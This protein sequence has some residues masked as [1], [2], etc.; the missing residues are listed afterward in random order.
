MKT[1]KVKTITVEVE[2]SDT[3]E[4]VYAKIQDNKIPSS[5]QRLIFAGK[6]LEDESS[7]SGCNSQEKPTLHFLVSLRGAMQIFCE[8]FDRINYYTGGCTLLFS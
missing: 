3:T 8:I 4:Y 2:L 5:Q 7:L 1:L 6:K